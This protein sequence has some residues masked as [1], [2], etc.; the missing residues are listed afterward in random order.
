MG[1]SRY[2]AQKTHCVPLLYCC[3]LFVL[4][5]SHPCKSE[6][7][8]QVFIVFLCLRGE[9]TPTQPGLRASPLGS[10]ASRAPAPLQQGR[11]RTLT[12]TWKPPPPSSIT[13]SSQPATAGQNDITF[14]N[15]Y[16]GGVNHKYLTCLEM[17]RC[18]LTVTKGKKVDTKPPPTMR[19]GK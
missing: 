18:A 4:L 6:W 10:T 14:P 19:C 17:P 1:Q 7:S 5:L 11:P 16:S 3:R 13:G 15:S 2:K 8:W 12:Y 9:K